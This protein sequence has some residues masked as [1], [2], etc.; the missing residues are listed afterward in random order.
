MIFSPTGKSHNSLLKYKQ[1]EIEKQK[2][3]DKFAEMTSTGK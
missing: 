1:P 2:T 3:R